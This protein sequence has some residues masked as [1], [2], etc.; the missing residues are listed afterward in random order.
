MFLSDRV[1]SRHRLVQCGSDLPSHAAEHDKQI[2]VQQPF[3]LAIDHRYCAATANIKFGVANFVFNSHQ[4]CTT[5]K[6]IRIY[7]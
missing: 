7:E 5:R 4:I 1:S 6:H 2:A 3:F